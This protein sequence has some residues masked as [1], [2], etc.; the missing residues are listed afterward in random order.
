MT[1]TFRILD[2]LKQSLPVV[3]SS[4]QPMGQLQGFSV[5]PATAAG[6]YD[7]KVKL[8]NAQSGLCFVTFAEHTAA[9]QD[10]CFTPQGLGVLRRCHRSGVGIYLLIHF[11]VQ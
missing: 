3:N 5:P 10:L 4:K 8:F 9:V 2:P 1:C 11:F 6:G 7:G